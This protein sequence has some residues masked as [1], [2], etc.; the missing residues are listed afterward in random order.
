MK[1]ICDRAA[2]SEALT[3]TSGVT[4]TRTPKPILECVRLTAADDV[5]TLTAYDQEMGLRFRLPEVEI[6]S[7]GETLVKGERLAAIVRESSDETL[8][9]EVVDDTL[10]IRGDDSHFQVYGQD[11]REFPPVPE[12]EGDPD[13]VVKLGVI[14]GL[15]ERTLFAAARENTR[16][17]INGVLFEKEGKILRLVATDGRRLA[18]S[19]ATLEKAVGDDIEAIIPTKPLGL[20]GRL[21]LDADA[22]IKIKVSTNQVIFRS[23]R[24]T[25]SSVLI[26]G[27]FPKYR[28]VMPKDLNKKIELKTAEVLSAVK[29]AALLTNE[30]SKGIRV[31]LSSE[32]MVLS[33]RAPEQGEATIRLPVQYSGET[34]EIGF[35]PTFLIDAMKV[36]GDTT[37]LELQ[38]PAKPGLLRS[39]PDFVYVVMPVNLS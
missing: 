20:L 11:V 37:T 29:R 32:G 30:E 10:H 5:L 38:A 34:L 27:R 39:D 21:H 36:C 14:R 31:H 24:V 26:E 19:T 23:E 13:F 3:A 33:S 1:C 9:F 35:N 15:I 18:M 8:A 28:D 4:L 17:A 7:P 25:I 6:T 22:D 16:Y 2:L 12:L